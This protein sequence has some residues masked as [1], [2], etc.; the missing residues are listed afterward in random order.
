[1]LVNFFNFSRCDIKIL[2][3]FVFYSGKNMPTTF[4]LGF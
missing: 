2:I 1:M 3:Y 4:I